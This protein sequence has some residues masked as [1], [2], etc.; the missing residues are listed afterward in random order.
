MDKI[1]GF[2]TSL[3]TAIATRALSENEKAF[4]AFFE[5]TFFK[6]G[7]ADDRISVIQATT[8]MQICG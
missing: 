2:Y 1:Q 3:K 6:P 5:K 4:V 8:L 7:A